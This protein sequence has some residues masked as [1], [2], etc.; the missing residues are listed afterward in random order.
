MCR[1]LQGPPGYGRGPGDNRSGCG[2]RI[3]VAWCRSNS[4]RTTSA[5][6]PS[7]CGGQPRSPRWGS[8]Q[9]QLFPLCRLFHTLLHHRTRV[10]PRGTPPAVT[11]RLRAGSTYQ[12]SQ[13]V[14]QR[15]DSIS[16]GRPGFTSRTFGIL[17][18][19]RILDLQMYIYFLKA[20]LMHRT[21][22]LPCVRI[23]IFPIVSTALRSRL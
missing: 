3:S 18:R 14:Y 11:V 15:S 19:V 6:C 4:T 23:Y 22:S 9:L 7:A 5:S 8:V 10:T 21:R 20:F 13:A 16:T 17:A 12:V 2:L 1:A